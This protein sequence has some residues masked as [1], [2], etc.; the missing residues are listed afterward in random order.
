MS[1]ILASIDAWLGRYPHIV[2]AVESVSTFSAVIVSLW[3][4]LA[5]QR[6]NKTKLRVEAQMIVIFHES[7]EGREKPQYLAVTITNDGILPVVIPFSF[8]S[9]RFLFEQSAALINPM[10]NWEGDEFIPRKTY[11]AE[12]MPRRSGNFYLCTAEDMRQNFEE[13]QEHGG[14]RK[15][16]LLFRFIRAVARSDDGAFFKVKF[17][18]ELREEIIAVAKKKACQR[19]GHANRQQG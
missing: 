10:D 4:A 1:T 11:P 19:R 16:R 5:S 8:F 2:A 6:A 7:L 9:W 13:M 3:I 17:S 18:R 14:K 15:R 12:I